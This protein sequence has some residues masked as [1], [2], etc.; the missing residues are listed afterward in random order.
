MDWDE[1]RRERYK[2]LCKGDAIVKTWKISLDIAE[3]GSCTVER[4]IEAI[5]IAEQRQYYELESWTDPDKDPSHESFLKETRKIK[6]EVVIFRKGQADE[7]LVAKTFTPDVAQRINRI[8]HV[9]PLVR[10]GDP[11]KPW[12]KF[13]IKYKEQ[14]EPGAFSLTGDYYQHRVRHITDRFEVEMLFPKGWRFPTKIK[15]TEKLA[16]G[17]EKSPTMGEWIATPQKPKLSTENGKTRITWTVD[18]TRLLHIY[19]LS[20]H[21]LEKA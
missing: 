15:G 5:N 20:Y 1:R 18:E 4:V 3:N 2:D 13:V 10:N 14:T 8:V 21:G 9:I 7:T 6:P 12:D 16:T 17:E 19:K 11:L